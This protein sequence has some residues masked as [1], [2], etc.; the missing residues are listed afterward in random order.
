MSAL[1]KPQERAIHKRDVR[2]RDGSQF[3]HLLT[4]RENFMA[5]SFH[6]FCWSNHV[7]ISYLE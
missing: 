6:P 2:D 7:W 4:L 5:S 1:Y 3:Y